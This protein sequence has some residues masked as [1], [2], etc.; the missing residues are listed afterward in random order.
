MICDF[1]TTKLPY[2][3]FVLFCFYQ[4]HQVECTLLSQINLRFLTLFYSEVYGLNK[5]MCFR[6]ATGGLF[7]FY[8][9]PLMS[10]MD[11][12]YNIERH[13]MA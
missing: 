4:V 9:Q 13:I 5:Q 2:R 12:I 10:I 1:F 3:S 11:D 8:A 6:V 7:F